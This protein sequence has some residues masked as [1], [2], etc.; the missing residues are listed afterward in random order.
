[1]EF[2]WDS[3]KSDKTFARRGFDFAFAAGIFTGPTVEVV[4]AR[5][6]YGKARIQAIGRTA[7]LALVVVYTDRGDVRRIISARVANK[8]ERAQWLSLSA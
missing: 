5:H 7:S 2:E 8:K 1:M 3:D 4:D 6:D